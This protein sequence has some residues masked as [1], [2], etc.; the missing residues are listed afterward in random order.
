M[1]DEIEA[2]LG[3]GN[4]VKWAQFLISAAETVAYWAGSCTWD[5]W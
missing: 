3:S 1:E 5:C 2:Q 4:P